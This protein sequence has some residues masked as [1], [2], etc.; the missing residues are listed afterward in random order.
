M[1][2]R[3][4]ALRIEILMFDGCPN[5]GIARDRVMSALSLENAIADIAEVE[6]ATVELA[7]ETRFLGSPSVRVNGKDVENDANEHRGYGLMCRTYYAN[8]QLEGSP[9]ME[10]I[11]AAIRL[12]RYSRDN[13]RL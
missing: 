13:G 5:A 11:R 4:R 12:A 1:N 9:S 7:Q 8:G 3:P 6:V 2:G 10:L